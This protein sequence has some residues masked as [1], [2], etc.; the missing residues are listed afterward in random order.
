MITIKNLNKY[1]QAVSTKIAIGTTWGYVLI[2]GLLLLFYCG[3]F[4]CVVSF[5][6]KAI[7][8]VLIKNNLV[9]FKILINLNH[10]IIKL[11][12]Q[13]RLYYLSNFKEK[14]IVFV[15]C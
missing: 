11:I 6:H 5:K 2:F 1:K 14:C 8:K 13:K 3:D 10:K 12:Y 4:K 15:S 7:S 9:D